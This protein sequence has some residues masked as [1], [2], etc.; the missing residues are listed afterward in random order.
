[1]LIFTIGLVIAELKSK[2]FEFVAI[3]KNE[4][5]LLNVILDEAS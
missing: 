5:S 2:P 4:I 1:M 3:L